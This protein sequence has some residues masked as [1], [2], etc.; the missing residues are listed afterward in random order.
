MKF[1][2]LSRRCAAAFLFVFAGATLYG[3]DAPGR[4]TGKPV[5]RVAVARFAHETCTFAPGGDSTIEDWQRGGGIRRGDRVLN[6]SEYVQGFAAVAREYGDM[7]LVG[8]TSPVGVWGGSSRS[9][10][11]EDAFNHFVGQMLDDLRDAMPVA[12]VFLS[13]HGAMAVRNIPRPEAEMARRFREVVGP[14]VPIVATFDLHGNEDETFLQ[15]ADGSFVTKHYPHY[16]TR[17]Q[18]ERAARYLRNVMRGAYRPAKAVQRVPILTATVLQWTGQ[19]PVMNIME[20]ARVWE[21]RRSGVF[22]NVFFGF[23]WADVPT[24]GTSVHVMTNNDQ[25]LADE[26]AADMAEFIWRTRKQW[27]SGEFPLPQQAV[28]LAGAAI[29]AGETPVVLADYWD[30]LGDGTWT[31]QELI[32]RRVSRVLY[33][34]LTDERALEAIWKKNIQPGDPF[35]MKVGGYTGPHAGDPVRITGSLLWRGA[36]WG[37]DRVAAIQFGEGN[38][39]F[40]VPAYQQIVTPGV[41][42]VGPIEPDNFEVFVLKTRVHFRRGFDETGYART[43]QIVDAPGDWFGTV[44]LEALDYKN[45][46]IKDFYPFGNPSFDPRRQPRG[47]GIPSKVD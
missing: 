42:R 10:N 29:A 30:R 44:R 45:V 21:N 19:S 39:I 12:G 34:A 27:A 23:P 17:E 32:D 43:I 18:G 7:E 6:L 9:W 37:Y 35:D 47:K 3:A 15:W 38:V 20:R 36:R 46:N 28:R 22:V 41:L 40:L 1:F 5:Y 8:L 16:D 26:I 2:P 24:L 31:L 33:A 11:T 25:K 13:L 14:N 4:E